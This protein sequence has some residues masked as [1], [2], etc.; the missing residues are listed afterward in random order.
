MPRYADL[1]IAFRK[2]D[3]RSY[4]VGF[5]F[6]GWGDEAEQ[7]PEPDSIVVINVAD[8]LGDDPAIYGAKLAAALFTPEVRILF[9]GFRGAAQQQEAIL[10]VRLSIES[11][12]PELHA[13]RWETL[14]DPAHRDAPLFVGERIVMSRFLSGGQDWRPIRLRPRTDLRAL[15]VIANPARAS[16]YELAPIDVAA[17][18]TLAK[19]A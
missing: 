14:P 18:L 17:E 15:V 7:R 16:K 3:E 4:A 2:R 12:A 13:V 5:R 8:L 10:R 9:G 19:Q 6:N 1:E 11:S